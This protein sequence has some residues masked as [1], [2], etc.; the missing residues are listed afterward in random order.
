MECTDKKWL[1]TDEYLNWFNSLARQRRIPLA[2]SMELTYRC[3][4]GCVHCYLGPM[5][6]RHY[7]GPEEMSTGQ[8]L[9]VIDD[10]VDAGCLYLL[11]TGGEPLLRN[12]FPEIYR[13]AKKSGLIVTVFSNGTLVTE[14]I[15]RLFREF[16]P[17]EVEI[18]LY[19]STPETYEKISGVPGSYN[20]CIDGIRLLLDNKIKVNLKTILMT[21]NSHE[22]FDI[23]GMAKSFGTRFRF[24]AAISPCLNGDNTPLTLRVSPEEAIDKELA[25]KEN[26]LQWKKF[27]NE[28]KDRRLTDSLY[29]CGAGMTGF[30]IDPSGNLLPCMMVNDI[31][32][33][34]LETGFMRGWND[35]IS[36]ISDRKS[37]PDFV[38]RSCEKINLCGY[39]P[40]FFRLETGA[41]NICSEYICRTGDLRYQRIKDYEMEGAGYEK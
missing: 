15:I 21:L 17:R 35:M 36:Q 25:N 2:G 14:E 24:D 30:H 22:L 20:K 23:E 31:H 28:S 39:C 4:L 33:N 19:G 10:I 34:L 16:P 29:G 18:S 7:L 8:V 32:C 41:E 38:C 3:N 13:Y 27:F 5:S 40:A 9:N 6:E 37:D 1:N 26:L 12:D 11:L